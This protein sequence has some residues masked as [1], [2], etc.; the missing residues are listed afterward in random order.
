MEALLDW[1]G[2]TT[3]A[4]RPAGVTG[5]FSLV[6]IMLTGLFATLAYVSSRGADRAGRRRQREEKTRDLQT[7][8][9]EEARANWYELERQ[10]SFEDAAAKVIEEIESGR[11]V[12]PGYT[13]F[14]T[15]QAPS[16]VFAA[17]E[18]DIA[19]LDQAVIHVTINYYRQLA[20]VA[21][22]TEDLR[23]ERFAALPGS[24]KAPLVADYYRAVVSLKLCAAQL[25]AALEQALNIP[26]KRR[27]RNM[28]LES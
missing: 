2:L 26:A 22:L 6:G 11:W 13:P 27:D 25:N 28:E 7:A 4:L 24:R 15:R 19:L 21:Q 14:L 1:L 10:G 17:I 18:D 3:P 5:V 12:A 9:R 23:S 20:V 8:I 16:V